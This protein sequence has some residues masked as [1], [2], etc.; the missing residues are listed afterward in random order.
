[1]AANTIRD[2]IDFGLYMESTEA[3][4]KIIPASAYAEEVAEKERLLAAIPYGKTQLSSNP[5]FAEILRKHGVE[6]PTKTSK[7]TGGTTYAFVKND[8][9]FAALREHDD[10]FSQAVYRAALLLLGAVAVG[11]L[12]CLYVVAW[13]VVA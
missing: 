3:A 5:Q 9:D 13:A 12:A 7:T 4:H 10:P 1:M 2:N 8:M 6:P 11:M